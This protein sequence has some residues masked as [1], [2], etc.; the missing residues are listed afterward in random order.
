MIEQLSRKKLSS[1]C[2]APP[3]YC[4]VKGIAEKR[5]GLFSFR[6][7]QSQEGLS[8]VTIREFAMELRCSEKSVYKWISE[9]KISQSAVID[10]GRH[11]RIKR[12]FLD[13]V[14]EYGLRK[15]AEIERKTY[16]EDSSEGR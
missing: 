8:M 9:G 6:K 13:F 1:G 2:T 7:V 14:K 11:L 12:R 16:T 10:L 4:S 5:E 3:W 15:A